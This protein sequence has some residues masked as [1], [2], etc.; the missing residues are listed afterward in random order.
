MQTTSHFIGITLDSRQFVDL[1]VDLQQY[2]DKHGL[3]DV[4]E[5]QNILSL[6]ITLFYLGS[7]VA[8]EEKA[9]ILKDISGMP[10]ESITIPQL[11]SGYF[12]EPGKERVC[13][14]GCPQNKTLVEM[15]RF[16][17]K[18]YE[19]SKIPEN[20]LA[21]APH[22]SLLRINN[23]E[24]YAPHKAEIDQLINKNLQ[25]IDYSSLV[26]GIQLF[27]VNSLFRPEIQIPV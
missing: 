1:F 21:F 25:S 6:H 2:L 10:T 24:L 27:Q 9:Q 18:K 22:V 3:K 20:Q 17:A 16:F 11:K 8:E 13:Y 23:P 26:K 5:F 15:N 12:G 4:V 14:L 7:S 19:Y